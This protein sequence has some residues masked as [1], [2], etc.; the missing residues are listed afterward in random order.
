MKKT[1]SAAA[2]VLMTITL[3]ACSGNTVTAS[4]K[5]TDSSAEVT[6]CGMKISFPAEWE[7]LTG[8]DVYQMLFENSSGSYTDARAL[9]E[10]YTKNGASYVVY[11]A[12]P[13]QTAMVTLT[14]LEI[15]ADESTG[16]QLSLEEYAQ[17]NHN[18]SLLGW[19]IDGYTLQNTSYESTD[20]GGNSGWQSSCEVYTDETLLMGQSEFTFEYAGNFCSLQVYY[21][22][23]EAGEAASGVI[24]GITAV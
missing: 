23:A 4:L 10:S 7:V 19:Q 17:T 5:K 12:T 15:T 24:S 18:N 22:T 8:D 6:A 13:D 11:A 16:E 1:I 21:H 3:T 14:T 9:K 2:A 20:I